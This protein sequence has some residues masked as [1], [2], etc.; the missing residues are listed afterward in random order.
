MPHCIVEYATELVDVV[1]IDK[2]L[3]AVHQGAVQSGLFREEDIKTRAIAYEAYSVGGAKA[4]F[5]HT[6]LRIL[7]GRD[8]TQKKQLASAVLSHLQRCGL[9]SVSITVEVCEMVRESFSKAV[10]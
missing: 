7:S 5:V 10:V 6:T 8:A 2:L 1:P 9:S 3:E 4:H